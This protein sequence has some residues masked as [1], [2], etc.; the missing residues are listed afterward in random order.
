MIAGF[1][2]LH[3]LVHA[4]EFPLPPGLKIGMEIELTEKPFSQ[5]SGYFD[6]DQL[7]KNRGNKTVLPPD[8]FASYLQDHP[9]AFA[10]LPEK[11]RAKLS[12][13]L[14]LE[15]LIPRKSNALVGS[16]GAPLDAS[17]KLI[18]PGSPNSASNLGRPAPGLATKASTPS[19]G[20]PTIARAPN[21]E[22]KDATDLN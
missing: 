21:P 12:A 6:F 4:S 17:P 19:L 9:Q 22:P 2:H 18:L 13:G 16:D 5:I 15:D 14:Q 10:Q 20:S 3:A 1:V 11:V 7:Q 8:F